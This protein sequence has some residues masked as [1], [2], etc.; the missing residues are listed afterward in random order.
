ML[1]NLPLTCLILLVL[2]ARAQHYNYTRF[3]VKDGLASNT[4]YDIK[5]D[6]DGFIWMATDAGLSRFDGRK[7][8]TYTQQDGLPSNE[9]LHL[10]PDS[11]GRLWIMPLHNTVCYLYKRKLYTV[12]ND[13]LLRQLRFNSIVYT[14]VE[15]EQGDIAIGSMTE[16]EN[17]Y[18]YDKN[19]KVT[20][21]G[22]PKKKANTHGGISAGYKP[23][24]FI[25]HYPT[26][27]PFT[28]HFL[29]F[30]G[31]WTPWF[32]LQ[33]NKKSGYLIKF[34]YSAEGFHRSDSIKFNP[35]TTHVLGV[36]KNGEL[37]TGRFSKDLGL[38]STTSNGRYIIFENTTSGSLFRDSLTGKAIDLIAPGT[39]VN[40]AYQDP[41]GNI[42]L[43]TKSE[44]AILLMSRDVKSFSFRQKNADIL[45]LAK[46][47][48][49]IY[50]GSA[51]GHLY[52]IRN[53]KIEHTN[54]DHFISLANNQS[55]D[56][57]LTCI[58]STT[59]GLLLGF[60]NF[61]LDFDPHSKKTKF[62][63]L[64]VIKSIG[65]TGRDSLLLASGRGAFFVDEETLR[66]TDTV[67]NFRAY[68]AVKQQDAY[69]LG[70]PGGLIK[71]RKNHPA[72]YFGESIPEMQTTIHNIAVAP[73]GSLW[74]GTHGSGIFQ[75]RNDSLVKH[76][77]TENGL[78]SNTCK[79]LTI[80]QKFI[81]VGT[82]NGLSRIDI[83]FPDA[84][85]F[86]YTTEDGLASNDIHAIFS[87][88]GIVYAGSAGS[89]TFFD[90]SKIWKPSACYLNLLSIQIGKRN[91]PQDS[92][93]HLRYNQ[94][95]I[96][97]NFTGISIRSSNNIL[98]FYRLKGHSGL[99]DSTHNNALELLA[100]PPG[101]YNLEVFAR[102]K[103]GVNSTTLSIPFA[104]KPPFWK[105]WWF[106]ILIVGLIAA[107]VWWLVTR[108]IRQEQAKSAT[109]NRI[110]ELEQLALRS[111]M[112]PHFIFNCLN[113]I[114]N[115]LL[116]NNFEKTNEYL[117]SFAHLIRQTLD[118]SSRSSITI[119]NECRYLSSYLELES[120]RFSHSFVY[121]IEVDP[122]I[123]ADNTFIPTM[124]L[125][126]YV[127]NSIRHGLRY[128]LDGVK[129]VKVLFRKRGNTLVC[130]V[131]DNGIGRK[132]ASEL[133]SFIHVEYQ[134]KGMT[135]TAERIAAL[136]RRQEIPITVDVID[137]EEDGNA[138]GTQVIVRFPNVFL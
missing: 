38:S 137:L 129:S 91:I 40:R 114:Q 111:Q 70:T 78:S 113:S 116:Q 95:S 26:L 119:E 79:A 105:T 122:A 100:L 136:N 19:N 84:P 25:A 110:N 57:R 59:N 21:I 73:D 17:T 22:H 24:E 63:S 93:S 133:K 54:F 49:T 134:S 15:N 11:K 64:D 83:N 74:I 13:S 34:E 135:L 81:W 65:S 48:S 85:I 106:R 108:R 30:D 68:A 23:H 130:I 90:T 103:F 3:T 33:W 50:A 32:K 86:Q 12:K 126:P 42:W 138:T 77:T 102:N 41:E 72:Y 88:N 87:D 62:S 92:L 69:Y 37:I 71:K 75:L 6:K 39:F 8:V 9:I 27:D 97:V 117:T 5:Q 55:R 96:T 10:Y 7:F 121:N 31:K 101:E 53:N 127:E 4:V 76:L 80:D 60:D 61:L 98:Y 14:I 36:K 66:I 44:G 123:D 46:L 104:I 52:S 115:F 124:I 120:M 67:L 82:E 20:R 118:N 94:N 2:S 125:Q 89:L 35:N 47:D 28:Q 16:P 56:N 51:Y 128:R 43:A 132:K 107:L 29:F 18:I 112:N 45:S 99:W 109:Q 131:E 1:R 58:R